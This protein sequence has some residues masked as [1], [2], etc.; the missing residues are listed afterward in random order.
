MYLTGRGDGFTQQMNSIVDELEGVCP[1]DTL[2]GSGGRQTKEKQRARATKS[3][4]PVGAKLLCSISILLLIM[5]CMVSFQMT[6]P[7]NFRLTVLDSFNTY[8]LRI[9]TLT[10]LVYLIL[11]GSSVVS[12]FPN[13]FSGHPSYTRRPSVKPAAQANT[14]PFTNDECFAFL[15]CTFGLLHQQNHV[16]SQLLF[17]PAVVLALAAALL[18]QGLG[19]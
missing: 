13:T 8:S 15:L 5:S 9:D 19:A 18:S 2:F 14:P 17:S 4:L 11:R 3:I 12:L 10:T 1:E 16:C 6:I 7:R